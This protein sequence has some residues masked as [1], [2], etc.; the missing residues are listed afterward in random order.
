MFKV[1]GSEK[2]Q[3]RK[4]QSNTLEEVMEKKTKYRK[5]RY[6]AKG[7]VMNEK[8]TF[9]KLQESEK[10][11]EEKRSRVTLPKK[12]WKIKLTREKK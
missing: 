10:E 6:N 1:Q 2:E 7:I 4:E 11:E 3:G 12:L 8:A 5:S 9:S